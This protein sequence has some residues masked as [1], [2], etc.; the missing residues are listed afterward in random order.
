MPSICGGALAWRHWQPTPEQPPV[1][2]PQRTD[3]LNYRSHILG[4][5]LLCTAVPGGARP[6]V[7]SLPSMGDSAGA[8]L[9]SEQ[10]RQLGEA[11]MRSVRQSLNV[12]DDPE[13]A[14]YIQSLGQRLV[15]RS[16]DAQGQFT[17][18]VVAAPSI[19][20]FAGPGGFIGVHSGL[21]IATRSESELAAV[22]AHEIAHVT[23]RHIARTVEEAQRMTLPA[24]AAVLA[25]LIIGSQ[26]AE[27]GQAA[28]AAST[29]G[30]IQHQINF[31]RANESEADRVGMQILANTDF[32]PRSMPSFFERL[33]QT[34]R[35]LGS[36]PPEFLSTHPVTEARI[37]ESRSRAD[38]YP[39]RKPQDETSY[40]L[41][42][43]RL[44][45]LSQGDPHKAL[46]LFE[47]P[48]DDAQA[49]RYGRALALLEAGKLAQA[50]AE[51]DKLLAADPDRPAFII[52]SA[53][54]AQAAGK[55]A[56]ALRAYADA[57]TL[58]PSDQAL[59]IAYAHA[60][61]EANQ[62]DKARRQL[63]EY[64]RQSGSS[65]PEMYQLLARAQGESGYEA[66]AHQSLSEYYYAVGQL[67]PA[68]QQLELASAL[69]RND[70]Y[71]SS[72]IE[73]RLDELRAEAK[74]TAEQ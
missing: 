45:V 55:T 66:D 57:L 73:A 9:S 27:L 5:L 65:S 69:T 26:N 46:Q 59:N 50:K 11:F 21:I 22:L 49:T 58:Y 13:V 35:L 16:P 15:S 41:I 61:L 37:S 70:F 7:L 1:R 4:L 2:A 8:A 31:T 3:N 19:N 43:A 33:Q 47:Q 42:K 17:F 51:A 74:L 71:R 39:A 38:Q 23:Q 32:D 63:V 52:L 68:I 10:E 53:R 44:Q 72:R 56:L 30:Q 12:I 18:F 25:A 40:D 29:A 64:M 28:L 62:P 48:S 36:R 20:A 14:S 54:V 34:N 60:L 24:A 6:D 67:Q